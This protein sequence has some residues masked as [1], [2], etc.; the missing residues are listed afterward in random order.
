VVSSH[1]FVPSESETTNVSLERVLLI[2]PPDAFQFLDP[3]SS[4]FT[5][6]NEKSSF[7]ARPSADSWS[8]NPRCSAI[9]A[10]IGDCAAANDCDHAIRSQDQQ[11]E[12]P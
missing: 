12:Y 4:Q 5:A 1:V 2:L 8:W 3:D 10:F 9:A 11:I 6:H 7:C